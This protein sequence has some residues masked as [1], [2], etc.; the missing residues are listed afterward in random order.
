VCE[1]QGNQRGADEDRTVW[2]EAGKVTDP[3][4][5][6][7]E[8]EQHE[9]TEAANRGEDGRDAASKQRNPGSARRR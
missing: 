3:G 7:A 4:A 2:L 9:G 6:D 1:I 5:T 8:H